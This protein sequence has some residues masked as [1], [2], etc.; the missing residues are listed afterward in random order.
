[1]TNY[2]SVT[3]V[4]SVEEIKFD[5]FPNPASDQLNFQLSTN[6]ISQHYTGTIYNNRGVTVEEGE[7]I[8]RKP[9]SYNTSKLPSGIYYF[10]VLSDKKT[11]NYKF[12]VGH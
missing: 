6:D 1:M 9:Y 8:P 10:Q 11:Y 5:L 12:V 3:V 4:P 7:I 2:T